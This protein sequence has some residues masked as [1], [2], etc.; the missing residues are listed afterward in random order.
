VQQFV[1]STVLFFLSTVSK[2]TAQ[3]DRNQN[4]FFSSTLC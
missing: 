3:L 2:V 1:S 4:S